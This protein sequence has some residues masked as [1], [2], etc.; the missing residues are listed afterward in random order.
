MVI[1]DLYYLHDEGGIMCW[2]VSVADSKK[3]GKPENN[4]LVSITHLKIP[5]SHQLWR[6]INKYQKR[7]IKR[8]RQQG[9]AEY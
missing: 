6:E 7:R 9:R 3:E 8:L 5:R 4:H 2:I 1:H